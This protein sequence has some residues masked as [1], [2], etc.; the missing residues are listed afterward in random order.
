SLGKIP[1]YNSRKWTKHGKLPY[2]EYGTSSSAT[3]TA[4]VAS[5][6]YPQIKKGTSGEVVKVLQTA[7]NKFGYKLEVDGSFGPLTDTAVRNY[8]KSFGLEVDGIVGPKT[9]AKLEV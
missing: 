5:A 6:S 1:G 9:W 7:L 2:V 4:P 8:Q 3:V